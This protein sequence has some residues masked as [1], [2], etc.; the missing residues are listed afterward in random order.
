MILA[1][2]VQYLDDSAF[3]AGIMF[4]AWEAETPQYEYSSCIGNIAPYEPGSF[5][6]RE[7]PCILA[8]LKEHSLQPE[9]IVIDGYVYLDG[10]K[11]KVGLGKRLYNSLDTKP[12]II[13]VAKNSFAG[14]EDRHKLTRGTSEKP[15]FITT[16]GELESAK[17]CIA[18]MHGEHRMPLLLKRADQ[19]CREEAANFTNAES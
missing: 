7:L 4:D 17:N 14:I 13:G 12:E 1:V 2:D 5:Y 6:K 15:L 16:T 18:N 3:V 19:L 10:K 11:E 9:I 8:L